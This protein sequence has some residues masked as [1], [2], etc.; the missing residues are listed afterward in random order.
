MKGR[1]SH[2]D[3]I[4]ISN[5]CIVNNPKCLFNINTIEFLQI[6]FDEKYHFKPIHIRIYSYLFD[7][8]EILQISERW[9]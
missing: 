1:E 7:L 3:V 2:V 5:M 6:F 9:G 4:E 8:S